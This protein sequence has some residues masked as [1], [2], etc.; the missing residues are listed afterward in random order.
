V[1][2]VD[3]AVYR[4]QLIARFANPAIAHRT[5]QIAM[6]GSQKLPQ[7]IFMPAMD[8]IAAGGDADAFAYVTA[9]WLAHIARAHELNDPRATELLAAA[10]AP[11]AS[12]SEAFFGVPG[13]FPS[14]LVADARWRGRVDAHVT[15]LT[16]G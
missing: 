11:G 10:R 3:L 2:G 9:L 1:P 15:T 16:E 8:A 5:A 13:L 4:E 14:A 12:P 7:R 6:D